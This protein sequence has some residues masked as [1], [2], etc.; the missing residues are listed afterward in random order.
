VLTSTLALALAACGS[1]PTVAAP[2]TPPQRPPDV[3]LV[4]VDALRARSLGAYGNARPASPNFDRWAG[5]SV[6]F[7]H[8]ISQSAWTPW[9]IGALFGVRDARPMFCTVKP[10][11]AAGTWMAPEVETIAE[12]FKGA[13]YTTAALMKTW[14]LSEESGHAQ[15]FDRFEIVRK[16]EQVADGI[17]AQILVDAA[18]AYVDQ[19]EADEQPYFLYL[20]FMDAHAPYKAPPPYYDMYSKDYTGSLTGAVPEMEPFRTGAAEPTAADVDRM[21]ALYEGE[22]TYWDAQFQRLLDRLHRPGSRPEIVALTADHGEA[23]W[24][25]RNLSH[26]HVYQENLH[27]PLVVEAPGAAARR[28]PG[29][30]PQ[31]ALGA[32]LAE[33]AGVGRG[34]GWTAPSLAEAVRGGPVPVQTVYSE[35]KTWRVAIDP[36]GKKLVVD[37]SSAVLYDLAADP[38][39]TH[40][41]SADRPEDTERLRGWLADKARQHAEEAK[42]LSFPAAPGAENPEQK[43]QLEALGYQQ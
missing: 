15:G 34:Q 37:P 29:Y 31:N 22:V 41:L 30:V 8:A 19:A 10:Q 24:E 5:G 42:G 6:L 17:S 43:M 11:C 9:S 12:R 4:L 23:F 2:V 14:A 18:L 39:E 32:T 20:H 36:S 26:G 3:I 33:L 16:K 1:A 25:H 40:D 7:E 21:L 35:M 13:G 38:G 27:V 28:V